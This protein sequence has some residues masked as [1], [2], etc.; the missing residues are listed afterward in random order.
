MTW[1]EILQGLLGSGVV[2]LAL[3][4]LIPI[5][6]KRADADT[7]RATVD[8]T[9]HRLYNDMLNQSKELTDSLAKAN[10]EVVKITYQLHQ[11][12]EELKNVRAAL[13]DAEKRCL[14]IEPKGSSAC[15]H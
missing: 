3:K 5:V 7:A 4:V 15:A 1:V 13:A 11:T 9:M 6:T 8:E 12:Q 2:V 10:A 14:L